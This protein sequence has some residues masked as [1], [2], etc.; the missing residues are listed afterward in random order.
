[1]SL[2][3]ITFKLKTGS[4][5]LFLIMFLTSCVIKK[6][7]NIVPI[8]TAEFNI[9][10]LKGDFIFEDSN[11]IKDS[12]ILT[13][14]INILTDNSVK[15]ITNF[16]ECN[17]LIEL[18]YKLNR[19]LGT[20][21]IRVQK[22][23][24]DQYFFKISGLCIDKTFILK[25]NKIKGDSLYIVKVKECNYSEIKE[26]A[27]RKFKIEYFITKDGNIWK[28]IKFTPNGRDL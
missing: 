28:P 25:R 21:E 19:T 8:S 22:K 15:S 27:F 26:L 16:E 12:L 4:I 6:D 9:D 17:H 1:M 20:I 23:E 7:C 18:D 10:K 3:L 13:N 14:Y 2:K 11:G 24:T 5:F